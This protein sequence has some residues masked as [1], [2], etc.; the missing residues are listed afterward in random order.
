MIDFRDR[1]RVA[2][3]QTLEHRSQH[4]TLFL[5]RLAAWEP[6]VELE[7]QDMHDDVPGAPGSDQPSRV[8][9]SSRSS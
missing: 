2:V 7:G 8:R 4:R 5:Q 6:N 9:S 3:A 1:H